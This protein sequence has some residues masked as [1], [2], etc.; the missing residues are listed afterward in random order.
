M[1][2]KSAIVQIWPKTG[3]VVNTF[4]SKE[5]AARHMCRTLVSVLL[6]LKSKTRKCGGFRFEYEDPEKSYKYAVGHKVDPEDKDNGPASDTPVFQSTPRLKKDRLYC[7]LC[8]EERNP[9]DSYKICGPCYRHFKA[10]K[11]TTLS[12]GQSSARVSAPGDFKND[13]ILPAGEYVIV[14]KEHFDV[15]LDRADILLLKIIKNPKEG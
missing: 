13:F 5:N 1:L 8:G 11:P 3:E 14:L 7:Q 9:T 15:V 12:G 6:S 10:A 4:T 2:N